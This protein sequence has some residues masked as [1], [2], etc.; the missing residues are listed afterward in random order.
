VRWCKV[1][2]WPSPVRDLGAAEEAVVDVDH[3]RAVLEHPGPVEHLPGVTPDRHFAV[4][5]NHLIPCCL[6]HSVAVSRMGLSDLAL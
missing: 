5:L 6:S 1:T 2:T 3:A 4:Q